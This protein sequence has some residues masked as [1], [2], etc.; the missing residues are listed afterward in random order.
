MLPYL[1]KIMLLLHAIFRNRT[2]QVL[3]SPFLLPLNM[4]CKCRVFR[5]THNFSV[6]GIFLIFSGAETLQWRVCVHVAFKWTHVQSKI[7]WLYGL[8]VSKPKCCQLCHAACYLWYIQQ[9]LQSLFATLEHFVGWCSAYD[10]WGS[11]RGNNWRDV[12]RI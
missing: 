10:L 2:F 8:D 4:N 3:L 6:Y 5:K 7:L 9:W 11:P 12:W 1:F